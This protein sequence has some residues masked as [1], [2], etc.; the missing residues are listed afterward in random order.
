M[1]KVRGHIIDTDSD[2]ST[3]SKGVSYALP[4]DTVPEVKLKYMYLGR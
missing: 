4:L 3:S 2:N 1:L